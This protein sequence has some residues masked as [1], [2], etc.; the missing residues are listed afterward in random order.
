MKKWNI[1]K[2]LKE[3]A[4]GVLILFVISNLF[5]YL[6][7]PIL[8]S[9]TLPQMQ[10]RLLDNT[11]FSSKNLKGKPVV[12]HF[13]ATW[14]PTCKLEAPNIQNISEHYNVLTIAV[15]SGS[16]AELQ[17]YI[18]ERNLSFNVLNDKKGIWSR[19]F[20]V[21]AFP[22]SFIYNSKGKLAFT[23]VGYTTTA[24]LLARLKII[25]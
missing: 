5:S 14:C 7:K 8:D 16:S 11:L 9:N 24:G 21:Q 13:W 4:I 22:T 3:L 10:I 12:I 6:R 18:R 15:Q 17:A 23:E 25:E 1:K 20:H 19:K 2:V